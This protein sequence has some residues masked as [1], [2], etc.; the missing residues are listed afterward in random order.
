MTKT[1]ARTGEQAKVHLQASLDRLKTDHLDLWQIHS[2]ESP[3]DVD[4]RLEA[5]VLEVALEAQQQGKTRY[6]GFTGHAS[7]AAHQRMLERTADQGGVFAACQCPINPVDA[8]SPWSFIQT[9]LPLLATRKIGVLAMKTLADGHFFARKMAGDREVWKT[10]DPV[11]P[12][13]LS[14]ADCIGFALS[15]PI[16]VLITGCEKPEYIREKAAMV[17]KHQAMND[18]QRV[19][20]A[21]RVVRFAEMRSVE[22]YKSRPKA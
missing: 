9:V 21:R 19:D 4:K 13:A 5:G 8:V 15:L 12:Q 2:L 14:I 1:M 11:I 16:S 7:P 6:L 20:L 17:R 3:G 10:D 18:Q 22:Y